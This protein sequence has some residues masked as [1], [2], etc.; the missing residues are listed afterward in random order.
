MYIGL[1]LFLSSNLSKA[2]F[3]HILKARHRKADITLIGKE[4]V[5]PKLMP[6]QDQKIPYLGLKGYGSSL[7]FQ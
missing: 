2:D 4:K 7:P 5:P 1:P 6:D 3:H